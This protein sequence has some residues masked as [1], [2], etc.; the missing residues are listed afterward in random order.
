MRD[1]TCLGH[2]FTHSVKYVTCGLLLSELNK[3]GNEA[4]IT[5]SLPLMVYCKISRCRLQRQRETSEVRYRN[6]EICVA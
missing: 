4:E 6:L 3:D 1:I 5:F 2:A